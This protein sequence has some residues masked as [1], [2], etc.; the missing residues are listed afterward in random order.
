MSTADH[1]T[2]E[3]ARGLGGGLDLDE[4]LDDLVAGEELVGEGLA[5]LVGELLETAKRVEVEGRAAANRGDL[6]LAAR[7]GVRELEEVGIADPVDRDA[8]REVLGV[9]VVGLRLRS[10]AR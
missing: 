1:H 6:G 10:A 7:I 2:Q 4:A 5:V 3:A 9:Q 8:Q